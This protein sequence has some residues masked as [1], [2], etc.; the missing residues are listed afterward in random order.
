V[1]SP[2]IARRTPRI[3]RRAIVP[4]IAWRGDGQLTKKIRAASD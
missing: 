2:D 3:G 4:G 1:S